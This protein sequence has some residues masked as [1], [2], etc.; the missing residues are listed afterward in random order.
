MSENAILALIPA[1]SG[2]KGVPDKNI[3][4]LG[5]WPLMAYS[6]KIGLLSKEIDRVIVST[7]S[8][9]YGAIAKKFGAEIPFLRPPGLSSDSSS[10][11][12][13]I[14]HALDQLRLMGD[15]I[16]EYI[17][18]LRPTTPFRD[19]STV[20]SAIETFRNDNKATALRSVHEMPESAYKCFRIESDHLVD[21]YKG[22]PDLDRV[23]TAR[24]S[25]PKTYQ[26]NGYVDVLRSK[27]ILDNKKIHGDRVVA[28][29]TPFIQEVDTETDFD[30]LTYQI[31]KDPALAN[32]LF[33]A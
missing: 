2:S 15:E 6:I 20:D 28:Y 26:G 29:S 19:P 27:F 4:P 33:K 17:V 32:R 1:R 16:P 3:K 13:F 10:D 9:D 12:E 30:F 25:F 21:A 18:H 8:E 22:S 24:Q 11:Y 5:G 14:K 31:A 7:D 23:N